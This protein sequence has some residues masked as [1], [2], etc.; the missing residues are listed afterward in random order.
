MRASTPL[1]LLAV[2]MLLASMILNLYL[3]DFF[4]QQDSFSL[5]QQSGRPR[6]GSAQRAVSLLT[7]LGNKLLQASRGSEGS[8]DTFSSLQA[9]GLSLADPPPPRKPATPATVAFIINAGSERERWE[10]NV[11]RISS[12]WTEGFPHVYYFA[13]FATDEEDRRGGKRSSADGSGTLPL[14]PVRFMQTRNEHER[15][16]LML[17]E[18][19]K[20]LPPTIQWFI[21]ADEDTYF[22]PEN[23]LPVLSK[24]DPALPWY[25]GNPGED[26]QA[27]DWYSRMAYGGGG[28]AF[29]RP[30]VEALASQPAHPR[31]L[32]SCMRR[33]RKG[34]VDTGDEKLSRCVADLGVAL[35][36]EPGF[37]QVDL[38][39][40]ITPVLQNLYSRQ[41]LV[42]LHHMYVADCV[43]RQFGED[44]LSAMEHLY[45]A[46]RAHTRAGRQQ[47]ASMS[48][49]SCLAGAIASQDF[50][51]LRFSHDVQRKATLVANLGLSVRIWP[52]PLLS[53]GLT[54]FL[55]ETFGGYQPKLGKGY[56]FDTVPNK[57]HTKYYCRYAQFEWMQEVEGEEEQ[58]EER[59]AAGG[60]RVKREATA[61][62]SLLPAQQFQAA[63]RQ[64]VQK[65]LPDG[66]QLHLYERV[67]SH[68]QCRGPN[69]NLPEGHM[70]NLL[71]RLL[72]EVIPCPLWQSRQREQEAS[73]DR[74]WAA[75]TDTDSIAKQGGGGVTTAAAAAVDWRNFL[76]LQAIS[77]DGSTGWLQFTA[78][79]TGTLELYPD[80]W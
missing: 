27:L 77:K 34:L 4:S 78:C 38:R 55:T 14:P 66:H 73:A 40:D 22:F 67:D 74:R 16:A 69:G 3:I 2:A 36:V 24:Y 71:Q 63:V 52:E 41:P 11:K 48:S 43:Y 19:W 13:G 25:L 56:A 46:Y 42:S 23:L 72:V 28:I 54:K 57:E 68:P 47:P 8:L 35:T 80:S 59:G 18:A 31:S 64:Q 29:S 65:Q 7:S 61:N 30:V 50:L 75:E 51:L 62:L 37:H 49:S 53:N 20:L 21:T 6:S 76:Q 70:L 17:A 1:L 9:R 32:E 5:V 10:R 45:K 33:Y 44:K 39:G 15:Y 79:R 12:L 58:E 60:L 26:L